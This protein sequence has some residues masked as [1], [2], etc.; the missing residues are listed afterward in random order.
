MVEQVPEYYSEVFSI[1]TNPWG[2]AITFAVASPK[3]GIEAHDSC[4]VR[5]GHE[6][7]KTISMMLRNQ[8]KSYERDTNTTIAIPQKVMSDLGLAPENW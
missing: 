6:T 5:L 3:D 7:A 2:V 4:V 1:R 8:L